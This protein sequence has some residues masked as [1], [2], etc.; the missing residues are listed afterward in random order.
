[1]ETIPRTM[2]SNASTALE[3]GRATKGSSEERR[4]IVSSA[5]RPCGMTPNVKVQPQICAANFSAAT[6]GW[7]RPLSNDNR[8]HGFCFLRLATCHLTV[9][10][11]SFARRAKMRP[12]VDG[13][14]ATYCRTPDSLSEDILVRSD[15]SAE[16]FAA[17][18]DRISL[19]GTSESAFSPR[20][21]QCIL[22]RMLIV[23]A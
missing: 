9:S 22:R 1:M 3:R 11:V 19:A 18:R 14:V 8:V 5:A 12:G 21:A 15:S 6:W 23:I 13:F 4:D 20:R 10:F 17:T 7:A 2:Q 16:G